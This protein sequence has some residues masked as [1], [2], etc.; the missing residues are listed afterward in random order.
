MCSQVLGWPSD[1]STFGPN[2]L[3]PSRG[4]CKP[5]DC[6]CS[7]HRP[8]MEAALQQLWS[9]WHLECVQPQLIMGDLWLMK[10]GFDSSPEKNDNS[11]TRSFCGAI[12]KTVSWSLERRDFGR[13][14]KTYK[15]TENNWSNFTESLCLALKRNALRLPWDLYCNRK[16][17][18]YDNVIFH[19]HHLSIPSLKC[20]PF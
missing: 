12:N 5:I 15:M 11:S 17:L 7:Q 9:C 10:S 14:I 3:A 1:D 6:H 18:A 20:F 13:K 16:S 2:W 19:R 4:I 8:S